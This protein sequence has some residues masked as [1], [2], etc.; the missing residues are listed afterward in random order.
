MNSWLSR[1]EKVK[2]V[3]TLVLNSQLLFDIQDYENAKSTDKKFLA[4]LRRGKAFLQRAIDKR[5]DYLDKTAALNLMESMSKIEVMFLPKV[6]AKKAYQDLAKLQSVLPMYI[7][8]FEDWYEF[9]IENTCKVCK[10]SDYENCP[11]RRVL[12]KYDVCPNDPGAVAR[13]QYGYNDEP[14][15]SVGEAFI[16]ALNKGV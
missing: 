15:G 11:A 5:L 6:E 4:D 9:V 12:E 10:R 7:S 1:Q 2:L 3:R 14:V 13:C 8:D 16:K